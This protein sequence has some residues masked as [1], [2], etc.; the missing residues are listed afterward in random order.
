MSKVAIGHAIPI[1]PGAEWVTG[2]RINF[3][4]A[5]K[6]FVNAFLPRRDLQLQAL[7]NLIENLCQEFEIP[8]V[9][10]VWDNWCRYLEVH[11]SSEQQ[12]IPEN[13]AIVG[14]RNHLQNRKLA[15]NF[16]QQ[17]KEVVA[18]THGEVANSVMDEPPFGY[19][20]RTLCSV[21]VDYGDFDKNGEYNIPWLAPRQ[22]IYR[23]GVLAKSTQSI[24]PEIEFSGLKAS[25]GLYIPT[26]YHGNRLYGP[27]HVVEDMVYRDWQSLLFQSVDGLT[28]K[29][30]PKSVSEPITGVP[31][32][33][34]PLES[35]ARDYDYLVFDYFATGAMLG[36]VSDKPVIYCDIGLRNLHPD[37]LR[38][39]KNR[40]QYVKIDLSN[41]D[42]KPLT[43]RFEEALSRR[44]S[45]GNAEMKKYVLCKST[46]FSWA[47][48]F[49]QLNSGKQISFA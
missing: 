43:E 35:C 46:E 19:S 12:V 39:L 8:G 17:E 24:K 41:L 22:T 23:D 10:K 20:E 1:D 13:G 9:E 33:K 31:V 47:E 30:H 4:G 5:H 3:F 29:V 26:T 34:R 28:F 7:R 21:L 16:L 42:R 49:S 44:T 36:L 6:T 48:M 40:C 18:V 32:E 38:D 2:K 15:V 25:S 37:F 27:F 11:T 45:F 14:T